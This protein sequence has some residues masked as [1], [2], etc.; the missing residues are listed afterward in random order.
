MQNTHAV[1]IICIAG[2]VIGSI[3]PEYKGLIA[4]LTLLSAIVCICLWAIISSAME[5]RAVP[6]M[7]DWDDPLTRRNQR[8]GI[9]VL[10]RPWDMN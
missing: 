10:G 8:Y 9:T 5:M 1:G 3:W 6:P 7:P 4:V 2:L